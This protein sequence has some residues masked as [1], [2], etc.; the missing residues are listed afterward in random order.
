MRY[1]YDRDT[2]TGGA[3]YFEFNSSELFKPPYHTFTGLFLETLNM[4]VETIEVG[5]N[6]QVVIG[7]VTLKP[8]KAL[9]SENV[10]VLFF[11]FYLNFFF[12]GSNYLQ[13]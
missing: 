5:E 10:S 1:D 2:D 8:G 11:D 3:F 6:E 7:D 9:V 13:P 4:T 12:S